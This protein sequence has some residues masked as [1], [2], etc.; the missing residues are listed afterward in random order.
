MPLAAQE[1][2]PAR[3]MDS[4]LFAYFD[5]CTAFTLREPSLPMSCPP[6][7][8]TLSTLFHSISTRLQAL[9]P[10]RSH[11][12]TGLWALV[13]DMMLGLF[14]GRGACRSVI[15]AMPL[16]LVP[17]GS[18]EL[19]MAGGDVIRPVQ[20]GDKCAICL[21]VYEGGDTVRHLHCEHAFHAEVGARFRGRRVAFVL[22]FRSAFVSVSD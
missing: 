10:R 1:P 12:P 4:V 13:V 18:A 19:D 6:P 7:P 9:L 11:E 15:D 8:S 3:K 17:D 21:G 14:V 20:K 22:A 2:L 5:I 16:Q